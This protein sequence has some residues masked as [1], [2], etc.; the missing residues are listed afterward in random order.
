M[1]TTNKK[2]IQLTTTQD[3][4][5][6]LRKLGAPDRLILHSQLVCE[7][8]QKIVEQISRLGIIINKPLILLGAVLHDAGKI[9]YPEELVGAGNR[10]E[11]AGESLLVEYGL[12]PNIARCCKSHGKL[13]GHSPVLTQLAIKLVS[14]I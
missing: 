12:A 10:R 8:A 7:V 5:K 6:F 11:E 1:R 3:A 2:R 14:N 13:A 9:R 4:Y